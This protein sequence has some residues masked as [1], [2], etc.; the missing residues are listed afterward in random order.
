MT[1]NLVTLAGEGS[2]FKINGIETIK[3]F[4]IL[5][6]IDDSSIGWVFVQQI[7][8]FLFVVKSIWKSLI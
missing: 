3:G 7:S 1:T 8:T 5:V 6:V 2:R 4:D